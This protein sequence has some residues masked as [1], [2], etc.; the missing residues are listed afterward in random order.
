MYLF[1]INA[2]I[3]AYSKFKYSQ[4]CTDVRPS[5]DIAQVMSRQVQITLEQLS[6]C[7]IIQ[8]NSYFYHSSSMHIV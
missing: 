8:K 5:T 1:S 6:E 3:S 2:K 7:I 4:A